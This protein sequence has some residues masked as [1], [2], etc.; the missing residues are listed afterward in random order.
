MEQVRQTIAPTKGFYGFLIAIWIVV[1]AVVAVTVYIWFLPEEHRVMDRFAEAEAHRPGEAYR[2]WRYQA[3]LETCRPYLSALESGEYEA[4]FLAMY[5]LEHYEEED[6]RTYR[7]VSTLKV[8][9]EL[10]NAMELLG[11]LEELFSGGASPER[12]YLGIDPVKLEQR[13]AWEEELDWQGTIAALIQEHEEV[14]WELL[15]SYPSLAEWQQLSETEQQ[16][17]LASYGRAMDVLSPLENLLLFYIG[18]QEWLICNQSNYT[19][20]GVLSDSVSHTMLLNVFCDQNYL[21][22]EDNREEMLEELAEALDIWQYEPPYVKRWTEDTLVF[23]GDSIFGNY[24]NSLSVPGVVENYTGARCINCGY[25]GICLS[26]G[27]LETVGVDVVSALCEGQEIAIPEGVPAY[28]GIR[29]LR[30]SGAGSGRLVFFLNYGINDYLL[31]HPVES[32]DS[33]AVTTYAGAMRTVIEQLQTAY[34]GAEIVI[35]TPGFVNYGD[36][37]TWVTGDMGSVLTVYVE[38]AMEVAQEYGLPYM[39][40]YADMEAYAEKENVLTADGIHPNERG[41]FRIGMMVCEVLNH[42]SQ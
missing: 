12:I 1:L 21:V 3:K 16:Q 14:Q 6:F 39:N 30:Q 13:L 23:L 18:G 19:G 32:E 40:N 24:T 36:N 35:M 25:G 26:A 28:S 15:L 17:A 5:S 37:G 33:H 20:E 7:G 27:S 22:T 10:S 4:I 11:I 41:R 34:P 38:A 8:E 42:L 2:H 31:G 29:E 9:P